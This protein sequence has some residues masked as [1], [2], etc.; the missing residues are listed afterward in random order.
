MSVDMNSLLNT[1]ISHQAA[2]ESARRDIADNEIL[3]SREESHLQSLTQIR[4]ITKYAH[5]YLDTLVKEESGKFIEN[6]NTTLDFAFKTI[7]YDRDYSVKILTEDN[8]TAIHL[9]YTDSSGNPVNTNI[10]DCGGGIRSIV[11]IL[12]QIHFLYKYKAEPIIFIDEGLSMISQEYLPIFLDLLDE[13]A[14]KNHL[15]ILL[16]THDQRF[17]NSSSV[18][19]HYEVRDGEVKKLLK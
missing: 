3:I 1:A 8:K 13:L 7:F 11:G 18:S 5:T 12:L 17:I 15:K 9:L 19:N 16:I 4:D 10:R 14:L 6:L 2:V